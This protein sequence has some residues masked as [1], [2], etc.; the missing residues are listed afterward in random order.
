MTNT[1]KRCRKTA[2][3]ELSS[4]TDQLQPKDSAGGDET[5]SS[6]E[7]IAVCVLAFVASVVATVYF[8]RT[9]GGGMLMP[10]NWTMSMMWMRM[11][12]QTWVASAFDFLLMWLAMM[13]VMMLPSALPTFLKTRRAPAS[14]SVMA[15]GYFAVWLAAGAGVYVLG[16]LFAAA[17][18]RWDSISRSVPMLSGASLIAAGMFQ[19]TRWK[20]AGLLRC[21]SPFG[22][23]TLCPEREPSFSLG[24]KQGAACCFCCA[25]PMLVMIVLGMM[26]PFVMIGVAGMIAV[27]KILP[28]PEIGA[29]F[30][31][32]LAFIAGVVCLIVK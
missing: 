16:V 9:M 11:P 12:D 32:V 4:M 7:F 10:G 23:L 14:L 17:T 2:A 5:S 13:V 28:R 24:C 1:I 22:C 15:T 25:T 26:N 19:F 27:E 31:G 3:L 30:V 20:L 6:S 21:R 18:M 29:R 8:C